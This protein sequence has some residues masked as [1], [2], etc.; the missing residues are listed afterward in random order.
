MTIAEDPEVLLRDPATARGLDVLKAIP[1]AWDET[2]VLPGSRIGELAMIARRTGKNWF[3]AILNGKDTPTD[4]KCTN[5]SFL[6]NGHY[7]AVI[8]SSPERRSLARRDEKDF[9][10][11]SLLDVHMTGGDGVL[12]WFRAKS[13]SR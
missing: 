6:G 8:L 5:L 3:L 10:A 11:K 2:V 9:T 12:V 7:D 1:A 13:A 4:L